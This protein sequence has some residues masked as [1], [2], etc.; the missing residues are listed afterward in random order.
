M[1]GELFHVFG[2]MAERVSETSARL[3]TRHP[4]VFWFIA[5]L[6]FILSTVVLSLAI[7]TLLRRP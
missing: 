6:F 5:F 3:W 7:V 4:L 2:A 1:M